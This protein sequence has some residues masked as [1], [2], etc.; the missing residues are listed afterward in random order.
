MILDAIPDVFRRS[1]SPVIA[2]A[3]PSPRNKR[4]IEELGL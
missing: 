4:S 3:C 2:A 1:F